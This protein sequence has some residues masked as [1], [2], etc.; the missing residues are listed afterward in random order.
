[1]L[2]AAPTTYGEECTP[3]FLAI[4][5]EQKAASILPQFITVPEVTLPNGTIVP[6]FQ[7]G[8]YACTKGENNQVTVTADAAP[9]VRISY[10]KAVELCKASGFKL[11]TET[12][13]LA[14]AY[15]AA[16][17]PANWT[18]GAVGKGDLFQGV[19]KGTVSSAQPGNV[20]PTDKTE[21]RWLVLSNGERICD[22]NGNV[23]QWVFDDVQG[24]EQGLIAKPFAKESP[25]LA[26][27]SYPSLKKGM[28]WRPDAGRDWY[29][30]VLIRG[31]DWRSDDNA[32]AFRLDDGWP[33]GEYDNLGFRCTK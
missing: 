1:M 18:K 19:R 26:T 8:Q 16:Q 10:H 9:W 11:I 21:R 33:D 23:F 12:Q 4:L 3:Y 32:G 27:A 24:D 7:V 30:Y 17:Q 25:S 2:T 5:A 29:G 28:G 31:S 15:D 13:W 14:I 6:S 22:F 20:E